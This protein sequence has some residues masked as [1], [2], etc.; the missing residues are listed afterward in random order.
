MTF[1]PTQPTDLPPPKIA[2]DQI[3]TNFA[4]YQTQFSKN[5][6]PL[7]ASNQGKH[8]NVIFE[9][10]T[11]NPTI[12]GNFADVFSKLVTSNS[13]SSQQLFGMI[14]Q[15]LPNPYVNDPMQLTFNT[16]NTAGPVY[17][18]FLPGGYVLYFG[19]TSNIA[20]PI[21]LSPAPSAILCII[22]NPNNFTT[23]GT[24]IPFDVSVTANANNFQ[25]KIDSAI[26]TGVYTFTWVCIARQ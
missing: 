11:V 8:D 9:K 2:V 16:V 26:A 17:Q 1:D 7:N 22:A 6:E 19:S 14:P 13:G 18:S 21:T 3:R 20:V 23:I 12:A 4:Q 25:F 15:F 10:Q 24:P 5:H